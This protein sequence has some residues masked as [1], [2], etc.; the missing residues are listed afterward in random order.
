MDDSLRGKTV[1]IVAMGASNSDFIK[2]CAFK[3]S[4]TQ[5][6]DEVW[7]INSMAGV[8]QHDRVFMMD[9]V[10]RFFDTDLAGPMTPGMRDWLPRHPGPIYTVALDERAPGLALYPIVDVVAKIG[11][12]YFNNTAAYAIGYAIAS[13]VK[14][15]ELY[16][17]DF[18]YPD[19]RHGAEAGRACCEFL[20]GMAVR[21]FGIEIQVS[22]SST[23]LD[24]SSSDE[25][26][27]Y[28]YRDLPLYK[29]GN[30]VKM[31]Y[32]A[33]TKVWSVVEV[34]PS[35]DGVCQG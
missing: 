33:E 21:S 13:E 29:Y 22:P 18:S 3:G 9:P 24:V 30:K 27:L 17:V 23:F 11:V 20:C 32:N 25:D 8:I 14:K 31:D 2:Q 4:Q 35:K 6:A 26:K 34:E 28:G 12:P 15:I 1:A 16:G 7:A 5:V 19:D 10:A